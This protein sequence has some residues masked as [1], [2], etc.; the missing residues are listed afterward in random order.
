MATLIERRHQQAIA[1]INKY[2][3]KRE[4]I[5]NDL[6]RVNGKLQA[7]YKLVKRYEKVAPAKPKP[8]AKAAP[9]KEPEP[10]T[11]PAPVTKLDIPVF[12][13]RTQEGALGDA[14]DDKAR[15]EILAKAE[16]RRKAKARGRIAKLKA[17]R[18]GETK[19]MPLSGKEALDF[20][21]NG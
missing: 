9:S 7:L 18:A 16:A 15:A 19:R 20:I 17:K 6:V 5:I 12:L 3:L 13:Q 4:K 11:V 10:V 21:R 1:D 2:A 14:E 8:A